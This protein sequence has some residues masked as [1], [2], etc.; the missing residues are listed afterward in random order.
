MFASPRR[1]VLGW[2]G[3]ATRRKRPLGPPDRVSPTGSAHPES[4][5]A[6]RPVS[7]GCSRRW[8]RQAALTAVSARPR[9]SH[10]SPPGWR[11]RPEAAGDR[12]RTGER[13]RCPGGSPLYLGARGVAGTLGL[14]APIRLRSL[15]PPDA[16]RQQPL[17]PPAPLIPAIAPPLPSA[18]SRPPAQ[19]RPDP[20][21]PP[22]VR[23][24]RDNT[25]GKN[26]AA[27]KAGARPPSPS[28]VSGG[29]EALREGPVGEGRWLLKG[30]VSQRGILTGPGTTCYSASLDQQN[31]APKSHPF[32]P[33][34]GPLP[35]GRRCQLCLSSYLRN[36]ATPLI[37]SLVAQRLV[38]SLKPQLLEPCDYGRL[39]S[40]KQVRF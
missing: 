35:A 34:P 20:T 18:H 24:R 37:L 26:C 11:A 39:S 23:M 28:C 32:P 4:R 3:S 17:R 29:C 5:S 1:W 22:E 14:G 10:C 9:P 19:S 6:R 13:R 25:S 31:E 8:G 38:L 36:V 12:P 21:P 7:R 33:G 2:P 40:V 30:P 27:A 16:E 15:T